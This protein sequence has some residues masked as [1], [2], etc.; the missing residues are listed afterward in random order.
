MVQSRHALSLPYLGTLSFLGEEVTLPE[1]GAW[2]RV[3][4]GV[5]S[6]SALSAFNGSVFWLEVISE[7]L[8]FI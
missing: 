4:Q 2:R 8:M 1:E 5:G 7:L 3:R 6:G